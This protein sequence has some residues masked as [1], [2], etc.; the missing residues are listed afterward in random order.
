MTTDRSQPDLDLRAREL[1][2]RHGLPEHTVRPLL[3]EHEDEG[4]L[5]EVLTN[6]AHFLRAP[7]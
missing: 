3:D 1:A 4:K 6:L 2:A 5:A 7:S